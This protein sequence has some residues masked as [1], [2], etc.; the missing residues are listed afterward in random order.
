ML[1]ETAFAAWL[2]PELTDAERVAKLLRPLPPKTLVAYP[3]SPR[4][5]SPRHDDPALAAP[6]GRTAVASC[7]GALF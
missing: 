2:D 4:V 5:N 3:V 1:P 6:L 7:Q